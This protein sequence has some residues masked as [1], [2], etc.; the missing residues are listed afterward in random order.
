MADDPPDT[1]NE[2]GDGAHMS[3][4]GGAYEDMMENGGDEDMLS[5]L[6][7][8]DADSSPWQGAPQAAAP[9]VAQR[10]LKR[11]APS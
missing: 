1:P 8:R 11:P 3:N 9:G 5:A 7:V 2:L 10:P 4:A 6:G